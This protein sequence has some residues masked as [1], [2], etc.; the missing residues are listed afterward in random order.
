[1]TKAIKHPYGCKM[2]TV[3]EIVALHPD[4]PNR[5][6]VDMRLKQGMQVHEILATRVLTAKQRA[7][8]CAKASPWG[9]QNFEF[10]NGAKK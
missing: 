4:R 2:L 8:R 9:K 10:M 7:Q 6:F 1:M 3:M 5:Q